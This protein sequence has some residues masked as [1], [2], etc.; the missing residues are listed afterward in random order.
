MR[1]DMHRQFENV[2]RELE[3]MRRTLDVLVRC[4]TTRSTELQ[5]PSEADAVV[6]LP[7]TL[8]QEQEPPLSASTLVELDLSPDSELEAEPTPPP[9]I[10]QQCLLHQ[11]SRRSFD[12]DCPIC[13]MPMVN[14]ML[15][16][17]VW[18]KQQCGRSVHKDCFEQMLELT[19]NTMRCVYWSV[20]LFKLMFVTISKDTNFG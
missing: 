9:A 4:I 19:A 15:S 17:L 1:R 13:T 8:D 16:E 6:P 7:D 5:R 3:D 11:A 2:Q 20:I 18:C 10:A 14:C 12:E